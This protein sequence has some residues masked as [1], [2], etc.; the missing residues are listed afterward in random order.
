MAPSP[1]AGPSLVITYGWALGTPG[2]VARHIQELS[3][4]LARAGARVTLVCVSAAGYS[5][6]PRPKLPPELLGGEVERELAALGIE[7][8][9]VDPHPLHW[10]LDGRGVRR[11]VER[12]LADR[13]VDL[14]LSFY[15]EAGYLPDLLAARGVPFGFIATWL[16]Y[17]MA[18]SPERQGKGLRGALLRRANRRFVVDP[19]RRARVLFANSEFTKE[20]LVEVVGCD[21][22]RIRVTY[23]GVRPA[24]GEIPRRPPERVRR[25]LFFGRL[26]PEKGVGD[27]L[28]AL[29]RVAKAGNDDWTFRVLGSGNHAHVRRMADERGIGARVELLPH[30]GDAA[31]FRELEEADLAVLPSYSES[32][33]LAIAEAQAAGLPVVAYRAGSVPEVVEDGVTAWLAPLRDVDALIEC[34]TAALTDPAEAHRRGLAGRERV[35]RLFSWDETARRVLEGLRELA[36]RAT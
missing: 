18:L 8:V 4:A 19:Y 29:G 17:R 32:F 34:L 24:F 25:L 13:P 9:R 15:N 14:V 2:G 16:S 35:K 23:L 6:F 10:M 1:P 21:P 31:L 12:L 27:A 11:A 3:R 7:L 20:E 26:V 33:G 22:A 28:E 36:G 30:Q 5:S